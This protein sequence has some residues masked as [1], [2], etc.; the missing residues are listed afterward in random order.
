VDESKFEESV[1]K[2]SA[3]AEDLDSCRGYVF[4]GP[5]YVYESKVEDSVCKQATLAEDSELLISTLKSDAK[6]DGA[7]YVCFEAG[8]S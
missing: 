1:C 7:A 8:G 2:Y 6:V 4:E 3:L 5:L